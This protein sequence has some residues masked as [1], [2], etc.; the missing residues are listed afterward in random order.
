MS[1]SAWIALSLVERVGSKTLRALMTHFEGDLEAVFRADEADLRR[2]PGIGAKL[3][4]NIR[5]VD[6]A[7]V[8]TQLAEWQMQGVIVLTSDD[9]GY[10]ASL[11]AV[12]DAPPTL[13]VRGTLPTKRA[14]AI[15]GT[16]TPSEYA[17]EMAYQIAVKLAER[18]CT[19]ISGLARGIDTAAHL[20]ALNVDG[21]TVG[22]LGSGVNK[23]YPPEN[24]ELAEHIC[25]RGALVSEVAP[26]EA[27]S[28]SRLVARNRI[29]S[30]LSSAVIVVE[31]GEDGGAMYAAKRA[32]EQGRRVYTLDLPVS[33]NQ[34]LMSE[35]VDVLDASLCNLP[36]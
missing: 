3:A 36:E 11:R 31:T 27:P 30:G 29:I 34:K 15:V 13:F 14:I 20:S 26:L 35:G 9:D 10:P 21:Q 8:E 25:K 7:H 28:S 18:N 22:V 2:I 6:L 19:V 5:A 1:R 17:R 33:G 24:Q 23:V 4:Q 12:A 32:R 16:R